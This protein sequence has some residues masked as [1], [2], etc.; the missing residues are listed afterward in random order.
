MARYWWDLFISQ[1]SI[2]MKV[3]MA[4]NGIENVGIKNQKNPKTFTDYS[5][6][7]DYVLENLGD[8]N[9]TKKSRFE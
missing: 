4:V 7:I 9:L 5:Q 1:R 2:S 6:I 8:Y 3:S